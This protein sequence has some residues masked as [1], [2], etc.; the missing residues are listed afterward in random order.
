MFLRRRNQT[1]LPTKQPQEI[2]RISIDSTTSLSSLPK[3]RSK[4][5]RLTKNFDK[6]YINP[7]LRYKEKV[8]NPKEKKDACL[9]ETY[10]YKNLHNFD[11]WNWA[12]PLDDYKLKP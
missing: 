1:I 3:L 6:Y 12:H 5:H 11:F 7:L 4:S 10:I 9:D 8:D 2:S